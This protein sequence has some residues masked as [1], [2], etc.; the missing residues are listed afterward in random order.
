M[1]VPVKDSAE[2]RDRREIVIS[3]IYIR[4]E[5]HRKSLAVGVERAVFGK[6]YEL[7]LSFYVKRILVR[8]AALRVSR[9]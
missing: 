3:E 9:G 4:V 2:C 8:A 1:V 7:G 6:L 5:L